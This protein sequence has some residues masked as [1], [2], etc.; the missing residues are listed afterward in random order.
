[1]LQRSCS[2][3]IAKTQT[4]GRSSKADR[5]LQLAK[6]AAQQFLRK[7]YG[8]AVL[9]KLRALLARFVYYDVYDLYDSEATH[10]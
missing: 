8:R 7:I 5:D 6:S 4:G 3:S 9:I 2:R 1:M 10:R